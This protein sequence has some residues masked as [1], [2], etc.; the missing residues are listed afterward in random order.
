M[1][2]FLDPEIDKKQQ[3]L[4]SETYVLSVSFPDPETDVMDQ[5]LGPENDIMEA[6]NFMVIKVRVDYLD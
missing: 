5:F 6:G 3:L 4:D 1:D 2:Q